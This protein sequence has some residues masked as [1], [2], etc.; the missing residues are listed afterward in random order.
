MKSLRHARFRPRPR[1]EGGE[2]IKPGKERGGKRSSTGIRYHF[3]SHLFDTP[4]Q[5]ETGLPRS[6]IPNGPL[7][8]RPGLRKHKENKWFWPFPG[9][10]GAPFFVPFWDT[11]FPESDR[12]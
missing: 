1:F 4:G 3:L 8:T 5:K 2:K 12:N 7:L 6:W 11:P 10:Q 9:A